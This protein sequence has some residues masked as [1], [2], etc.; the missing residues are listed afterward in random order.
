MTSVEFSQD[1]RDALE[2][3]AGTLGET[4]ARPIPDPVRLID[5]P[6]QPPM[7]WLIRDV[8]P[9]GQI[10]LLVGDGGA[11]KS[12]CALQMACS[13]SNGSRVFDRYI[14]DQP[15]PVLIVSAEDD[16]GIV[17]MRVE[18]FVAGHGMDRE[19]VLSNIHVIADEEPS[20]GETAWQLHLAA[21]VERIRPVLIILDPWAE[22]LSG[23]E[24]SNSEV[25]P[26]I[27]F[28]RRLSR[29]CGS[30][31][32]LVHHAGKQGKPDEKRTLDKIRGA[33][34]LPSAARVI[35]FFESRPDGVFVENVKLSRAER[36]D[37][38]L[39]RRE[40]AHEP[41]NRGQWTSAKLTVRAALPF[42]EQWI[43]DTLRSHAKREQGPTSTQIREM[44]AG[45][46]GLRNQEVDRARKKLEFLGV[47]VATHGRGST[48]YWRLA[49]PNY[50]PPQL[51][52]VKDDRQDV[53]DAQDAPRRPGISNGRDVQD[54]RD[55]KASQKVEMPPVKGGHLN[56]TARMPAS[57]TGAKRAGMPS[58]DPWSDPRYTPADVDAELDER[59][60]IQDS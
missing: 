4:T 31:I 45:I 32:A 40:I 8:W 46:V 37:S 58:D 23:D 1:Y 42:A 20:I 10:G 50:Q 33:S 30:A 52:L 19:A 14:V 2:R 22:L 54:A 39:I 34:A 3:E 16:L 43:I 27:K 38:F 60:G 49:D 36:L 29:I 26:A 56:S 11:F 15:G 9:A 48:K 55:V 5:A 57:R 28:V 18:A 24:N 51:E 7:S 59:R 44:S 13:V 25:R 17:L 53:Q 47:I 35:L 21:H 12:S 6:P 41:G